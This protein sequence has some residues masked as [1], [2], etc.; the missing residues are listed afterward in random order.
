MGWDRVQFGWMG[1]SG[2]RWGA[3]GWDGVQWSEMVCN[4]LGWGVVGWD[5]VQWG[6]MGCTGVRWVQCH[7]ADSEYTQAEALII[8]YSLNNFPRSDPRHKWVLSWEQRFLEVVRDF[9]RNH[10]QN[11]SISFMAEVRCTAGGA[12]GHPRV[13]RCPRSPSPCP[14]RSLEDEIN[15]TTGEDIPVFAVSYL[16][17]FAYIALALGEYTAWRRV[18]VT[19][20]GSGRVPAPEGARWVLNGRPRPAAGRVEGDAGAGRHRRG[21]GRRL[22]LHGLPGTAGAAFIP[23]H[24]RGRALPR[25][26]RGC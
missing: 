10:S 2:V 19:A 25:P 9:Q 15:R 3:L 8:T 5:E 14:Q 23:H 22:R 12:G 24:P 11:L 26:R 1:C 18:L 4:G 7:A 6:G 13:P 16:V 20:G 21:A 17:V